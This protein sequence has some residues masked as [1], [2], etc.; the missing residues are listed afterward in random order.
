MQETKAF[1]EIRA[2]IYWWLSGVF[3]KAM[4]EQ[5][6]NA[7]QSDDIHQFLT[8]LGNNEE[9]TQSCQ[10]LLQTLDRLNTYTDAYERVQQSYRELFSYENQSAES[11][12]CA[13]TYNRARKVSDFQRKEM[14]QMLIEHGIDITHDETVSTDHI[15][16]ELDFL[17][18]M[19]V[20]SNELEKLEHIYRAQNQQKEFIEKQLLTWLPDF[21]LR[22]QERDS[23]GF[24]GS[25][26][27]LLNQFCH[28]DYHYLASPE[29]S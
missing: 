6:F 25:F 26:A 13:S 4:S 2:E 24:Y 7:Y 27:E 18:N 23:V 22:C 12:A 15:S 3:S 28:L 9:L 21:S 19:I 17:A 16:V 11:I 8:G 1:N 5:E 10:H 20:R 14:Y 29:P